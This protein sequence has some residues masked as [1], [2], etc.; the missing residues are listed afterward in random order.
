MPARWSKARVEAQD[1][2]LGVFAVGVALDHQA[3]RLQRLEGDTLVAA[4]LVD[5]VVIAER[6]EV[7]RI[8]GIFLAGVEV[9]VALR[10]DQ[11]ILVILIGVIRRRR[12]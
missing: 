12:P 6:D 7:L 5:L 10:R 1:R 11:R 3:Q 9:E 4:D 2:V 8:G